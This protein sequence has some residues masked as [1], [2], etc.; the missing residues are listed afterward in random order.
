MLLRNFNIDDKMNAALNIYFIL[1][2]LV[3]YTILLFLMS[4]S[5]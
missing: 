5:I 3:S 4:Y 2:Y 1:H